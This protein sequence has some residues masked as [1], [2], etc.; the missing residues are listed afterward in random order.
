MDTQTAEIEENR[1]TE[2][3]RVV[4]W[5]ARNLSRAGYDTIAADAISV[6]TDIDLHRALELARNGCPHDVAL[7]ILL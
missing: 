1:L 5:R 7:Q 4:L 6:R 3:E 2:E